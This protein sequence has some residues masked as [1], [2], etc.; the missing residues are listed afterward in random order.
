MWVANSTICT[1]VYSLHK[2]LYF[3]YGIVFSQYQIS[4]FLEVLNDENWINR[5]IS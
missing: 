3:E 5:L 1:Y 4:Y 2:N